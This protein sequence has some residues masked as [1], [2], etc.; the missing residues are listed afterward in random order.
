MRILMVPVAVASAPTEV[1]THA[2]ASA[3]LAMLGQNFRA[4]C[5]AARHGAG[6]DL[7][8]NWLSSRLT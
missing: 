1:Y 7:L 3:L 8:Q 2:D 4:R 5:H 6:P